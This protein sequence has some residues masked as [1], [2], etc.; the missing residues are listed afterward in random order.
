MTVDPWFLTFVPSEVV[1]TLHCVEGEFH[2]AENRED[3]SGELA[4]KYHNALRA[5]Q[6]AL[7][8]CPYGPGVNLVPVFSH[9]SMMRDRISEVLA[10]IEKEYSRILDHTGGALA[11]TSSDEGS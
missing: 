8:D 3:V 4:R 9:D 5:Y 2:D 7:E 10:G 6:N 11:L 1:S